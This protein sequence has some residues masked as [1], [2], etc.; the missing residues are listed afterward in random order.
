MQ[1]IQRIS[2]EAE[3]DEAEAPALAK[4]QAADR[5]PGQAQPARRARSKAPRAAD[6]Y[7]CRFWEVP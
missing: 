5:A 1:E 7:A 4:P 3:D 2:L 6:K